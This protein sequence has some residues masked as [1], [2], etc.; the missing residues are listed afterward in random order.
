M[1]TPA[2]PIYLRMGDH[3]GPDSGTRLKQRAWAKVPSLIRFCRPSSWTH[4][5][6]L[7]APFDHTE[8]RLAGRERHVVGYDRLVSPFSVSAP[9]S[10][11]FMVSSTA[12]ATRCAM[13]I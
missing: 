9:T 4:I 1:P 2:R 3:R 10:S 11:S 5:T 6:K 8:G 7:C 13:R 12:T